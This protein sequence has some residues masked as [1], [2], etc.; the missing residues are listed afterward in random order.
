MHAVRPGQRLPRAVGRGQ[1][2]GVRRDQVLPG[3]RQADAE[4]HDRHVGFEGRFE[5]RAQPGGV[6][7][8]LQ[9]QG[10]HPGLGQ[11][12][13][14]PGVARGGG[15]E[16]LPGRDGHAE[17]EPAARA[18]QRGEHRAGVGDQGDRPGRHR[19]R[20]EVPDGPQPAG[21]VDEPHAPRPAHG[22][23]RLGGDDGQPVPQPGRAVSADGVSEDHGGTGLGACAQDQLIL[24]R[25]V[26]H[27]EQ[28]QVDRFGHLG[29]ARQAGHAADVGVA[30][31]DQVG[32][33]PGRAAG[34]LLD[35][36]RAEAPGPG[37]GPDQGDAA[38]LQHGGHRTA[39]WAGWA[40]WACCAG[41]LA[42]PGGAVV[43]A[44]TNGGS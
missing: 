44:V 30:R 41:G 40:G 1:R 31:V 32:A 15:D 3:G 17:A 34:H 14:V 38:R 13:G 4:Q 9:D 7:D 20:L 10:Q 26:G 33:R 2:A 29:Q 42:G 21:H 43:S 11:A 23:V 35:H 28:D 12:Q 6:P 22:Q 27:R 8:R 25:G 39:G 18:Q 24:Q 5:R 19:V 37:A 16:L 36:P